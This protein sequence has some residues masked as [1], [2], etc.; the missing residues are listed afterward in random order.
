MVKIKK[1][2]LIMTVPYTSFK[3]LYEPNGWK[4]RVVKKNVEENNVKIE[5]EE[6]VEEVITEEEVDLNS[7]NASELREYA[8]QNGIDVSE[9]NSKRELREIIEAA[10]AI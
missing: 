4:M 1:G 9:A 7:M 2:N 10:V 6:A 3:N 5:N 8:K